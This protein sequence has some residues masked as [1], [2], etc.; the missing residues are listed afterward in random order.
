MQTAWNS[1]LCLYRRLRDLFCLL[2]YSTRY[3]L[4]EEKSKNLLLKEKKSQKAKIQNLKSRRMQITMKKTR[5]RYSRHRKGIYN[6]E[7]KRV[8][9]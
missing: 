4:R 2:L 8:L 9:E 6:G 1:C 3:C 5:N 7:P